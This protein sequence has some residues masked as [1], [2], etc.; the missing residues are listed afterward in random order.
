MMKTPN[1]CCY[2][3]KY[4][5]CRKGKEGKNPLWSV[6]APGRTGCVRLS[7][8]KKNPEALRRLPLA[9]R[10]FRPHLSGQKALESANGAK[11]RKPFQVT[12]T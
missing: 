8:T 4:A 9:R 12:T 11:I 2:I 1:D 5:D 6:R 3:P 10:L 7:R